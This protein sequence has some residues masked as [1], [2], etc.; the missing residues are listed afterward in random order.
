MVLTP[1]QKLPNNAGNLG[2][3]IVATSFEWLPRV[4][5]KS[6]NLVTLVTSQFQKVRNFL[7]RKDAI[8]LLP[9]DAVL[10]SFQ[11]SLIVPTIPTMYNGQNGMR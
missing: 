11:F 9:I 3:I 7:T 8:F 10:G 1:L 2:K 4:Q 6:P 5:K